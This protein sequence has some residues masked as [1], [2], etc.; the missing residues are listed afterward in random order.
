MVVHGDDFLAEAVP[1]TLDWFDTVMTNSF[2][3]KVL[4]RI[5]P[6][7]HGSGRYL[8]RIITYCQGRGFTYEAD[9]KHAEMIVADLGMTDANAVGSPSCKTTGMNLPNAHDDLPKPRREFYQKVTGRVLFLS[10]DRW[11]I[12]FSSRQ[13][14]TKVKTPREIDE[15]R[16]RRVGRYLKGAKRKVYFY[17]FQF[18][19]RTVIGTSDS[20]WAGD[21]E[22]RKSVS[23]GME[24]RGPMRHILNHYS[25]SQQVHA[26]SSAESAFYG[27]GTLAAHLLFTKHLLEEM[28]EGSTVI[29]LDGDSSG[30]KGMCLRRGAGKTRHLE[31]RHL[32]IQDRV[33]KGELRIR[34]VDGAINRADLGTK[35]LAVQRFNFLLELVQFGLEWK[36]GQA[37]ATLTLASLP[38][39]TGGV[40]VSQETLAEVRLSVVAE[41][42][43][44][45]LH[46]L[47]FLFAVIGFSSGAATV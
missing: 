26:I 19:D 11:D 44:V 21:I 39:V 12:N 9:P 32:W 43:T 47:I 6:G 38:A 8:N 37:V 46:G 30:A 16:L 1:T 3:T 7:A 36:P 17:A 28:F 24:E 13:L 40:G 35:E 4:K 41:L 5:G 25:V 23:A 14:A 29:F 18:N 20:D 27:Y 45:V 10:L 15:A 42:F 34:K 33:A 22:D 31:V 2:M